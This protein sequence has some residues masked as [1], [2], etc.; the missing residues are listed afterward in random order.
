LP[1]A[2]LPTTEVA[3]EGQKT[4]V[5]SGSGAMGAEKIALNGVKLGAGSAGVRNM[6]CLVPK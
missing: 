4:H 5:T 1:F 6:S 3:G 2:G